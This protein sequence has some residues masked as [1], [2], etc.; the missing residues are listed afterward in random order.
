[1]LE[2]WR[3]GGSGIWKARFY[4]PVLSVGAWPWATVEVV[5]A[6]QKER[7]RKRESEETVREEKMIRC[8]ESSG[9]KPRSISL[10]TNFKIQ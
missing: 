10:T 4:G 9:K 7:R 5:G 6:E 1:M 8:Y 2:H 3:T